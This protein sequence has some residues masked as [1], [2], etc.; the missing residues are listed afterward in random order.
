MSI[1]NIVAKLLLFYDNGRKPLL[2]S[3]YRFLA[4][5]YIQLISGSDECRGHC[6]NHIITIIIYISS[7]FFC[8]FEKIVVFLQKVYKYS[9]PI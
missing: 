5:A 6:D 8:H 7:S 3:C 4:V 9:I 2:K 1:I